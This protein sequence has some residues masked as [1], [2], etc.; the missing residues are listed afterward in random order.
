MQTFVN[1]FD[2]T[3]QSVNSDYEAKRYKNMTLD[4]PQMVIAR[5]NLFFDWLKTYKKVGGQN[6]VPRLQN[7]REIIEQLLE[8]NRI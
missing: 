5:D 4:L 1:V 2:Q 6:K 7:N 8:M 3:L